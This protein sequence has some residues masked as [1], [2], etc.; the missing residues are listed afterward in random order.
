MFEP[1]QYVERKIKRY[2]D[3]K[4]QRILKQL[5][6]ENLITAQHVAEDFDIDFDTIYNTERNKV[7]ARRAEF[8]LKELEGV[9]NH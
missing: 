8:G 9:N 6:E 2:F 1:E 3:L 7:N 5:A 4:R